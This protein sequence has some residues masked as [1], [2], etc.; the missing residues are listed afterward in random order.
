M[1]I[2]ISDIKEII[3][4]EYPNILSILAYRN[5]EKKY[6]Y[7][8]DLSKDNKPVH[9]ASVTKSIISVLVGIAIKKGFITSVEDRVLDY[10]PDYPLKGKN[11]DRI[12]KLKVLKIRH[13][14]TMTAPYS[15]K[16]EPYTK[17]YSSND[18][19]STVLS[20]L[21][22][23]GDIGEFK[24]TTV[25]MQVL[26]GII[27]NATKKSVRD[28]ANETLF[29]PLGISNAKDIQIRDKIEY[30]SFI[31]E[32]EKS[33]WVSD[34]SGCNSAGWGLTLSVSEMIKI[35]QLYLNGGKWGSKE[36]ITPE[37]IKTS[38]M[39]HIRSGGRY[40]GFL[41]WVIDEHTGTFAA[42]GDGGNVIYVSTQNDIVIA[43]TSRFCS[44]PKDRIEL[45]EKY[46]IP[47]CY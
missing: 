2:D 33:G 3:K 12:N 19:L 35:G 10:F 27:T 22:R 7:F 47:L 26:S 6:E 29:S 1:K 30:M 45:I 44:R 9:I 24:Y 40:Y 16:S 31:K 38:T 42:I 39:K 5:D 13:L 25:G 4:N 20:L 43:I 15:Y 28:F 18:W 21:G 37:W 32:S 36:I 23:G 41:W 11:K 17:V 34:P 8:S 46:I 14:L